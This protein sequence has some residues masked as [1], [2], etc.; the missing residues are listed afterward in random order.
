MN[1]DD[2]FLRTCIHLVLQLMYSCLKNNK[3][4]SLKITKYQFSGKF[5]QKKIVHSIFKEYYKEL[6]YS[7]MSYETDDGISNK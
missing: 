7:K 4:L 3:I 1:S 2:I 6:Q 5:K